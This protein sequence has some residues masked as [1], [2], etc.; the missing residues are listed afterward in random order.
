[1]GHLAEGDDD[2]NTP[3]ADHALI[4]LIPSWVSTRGDLNDVEALNVNDGYQWLRS[5]EPT[6]DQMLTAEFVREL[7]GRMFGDV[8]TWAGTYRRTETNLGVD[9]W[10][11]AMRVTQ[12]V[13]DLRYRAEHTPTENSENID[14]TCIEYHHRMVTIHPFPNGNGRHSRA[15]CDALVS[16]LGRPQFTWGRLSI[17]SDR[18][19]RRAYIESL[20]SA[21]DGDLTDLCL[22]AR[23]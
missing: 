3:W 23:S 2:A 17:V 5:T 1:M 10:E 9:W 14:L 6:I 22:F 4:G 13:D 11:I 12:L 15:F 18:A 7:H 21:D 16:A 20:Q 19:T 8:W